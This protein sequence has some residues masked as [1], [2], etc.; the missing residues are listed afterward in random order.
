[1]ENAMMFTLICLMAGPLGWIDPKIGSEKAVSPPKPPSDET[2]SLPAWVRKKELD[3]DYY[4]TVPK[5]KL[6]RICKFRFGIFY[7]Q[8]LAQSRLRKL[9]KM[10][11]QNRV[12]M[13]SREN[14]M[15]FMKSL[16]TEVDGLIKL[17]NLNVTIREK[18]WFGSVT[19]AIL[20][21][22]PESGRLIRAKVAQAGENS[23]IIRLDA[24]GCQKS[25]HD[26]GKATNQH[27]NA[28]PE[29]E[30]KFSDT[31]FVFPLGASVIIN[32]ETDWCPD[33]DQN[34]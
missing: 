11:P 22:E 21:G 33:P 8:G 30:L 34:S 12:L 2:D 9:L 23:N 1:M 28:N 14:A 29:F 5:N 25:I 4:R 16:G 7:V 10:T 13:L 24:Q 27:W 17:D 20:P 15:K 26:R 6:G 32:I 18:E 31:C 3:P 19:N